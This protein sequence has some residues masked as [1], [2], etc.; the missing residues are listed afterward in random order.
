MEVLQK[1]I[2]NQAVMLL[3][4]SF[5]ERLQTG[6]AYTIL[7]MLIVFVVLIFISFLISLFKYIPRIQARLSRDKETKDSVSSSVNRVITNIEENEEKELMEDM[8]LVSVITAAIQAYR[9]EEYQGTDLNVGEDGFI[10][11]S[12]RKTN[13]GRR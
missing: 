11:R 4:K 1:G 8:E 13:Y 10:V 6:V 9:E 7:G 3:E 5:A 12:I 2:S